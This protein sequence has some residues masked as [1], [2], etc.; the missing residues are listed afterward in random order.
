M[1]DDKRGA[2][3]A[4][5]PPILG[6][7]GIDPEAYLDR[8]CRRRQPFIRAIGRADRLREA[9]TA[10]GQRFIKGISDANILFP[11]GAG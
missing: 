10:F 6:R 4:D 8:M 7:L 3:A 5:A 11:V 1:R 9:A 2:I